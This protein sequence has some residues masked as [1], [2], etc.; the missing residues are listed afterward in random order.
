MPLNKEYPTKNT[1]VT[2]KVN[3]H[4]LHSP[5]GVD[6]WAKEIDTMCLH[7]SPSNLK[8]KLGFHLQE[9]KISSPS[10]CVITIVKD[11]PGVYF[12]N[13]DYKLLQVT[14]LSY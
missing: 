2:P 3:H 4:T 5:L 1:I 13:Y 6:M 8:N 11:E 7:E 10:I 12:L 9:P 14:K